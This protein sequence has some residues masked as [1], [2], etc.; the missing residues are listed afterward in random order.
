VLQA[1]PGARGILVDQPPVL[2]RARPVLERHRVASR[3]RLHP[4]D[5]FA[6]PP[7]ADLYVLASVLHDWDD[8][9]A[10]RILTALGHSALFDVGNQCS[11]R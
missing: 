2:E 3:C 6:P 10:A 8:P 11:T 5:L 4:G 7:P 9:H 1:T